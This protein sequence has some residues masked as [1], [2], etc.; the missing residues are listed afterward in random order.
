MQGSVAISSPVNDIPYTTVSM[1]VER[2][3]ELPFQREADVLWS[4]SL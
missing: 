3:N 4:L 2:A 1:A